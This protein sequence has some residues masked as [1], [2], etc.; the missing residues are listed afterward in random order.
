MTC[1][2]S[3][4]GSP[5]SKR[6]CQ[7]RGL[8]LGFIDTVQALLQ[9][10]GEAHLGCALHALC[11]GQIRTGAHL[12]VTDFRLLLQGANLRE[13]T[14]QSC[15]LLQWCFPY[16]AAGTSTPAERSCASL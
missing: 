6:V 15:M 13:L 12:G 4:P 10:T 1:D 16:P 9:H 14:V 11:A 2:S 5:R 7:I 8:L 3:T